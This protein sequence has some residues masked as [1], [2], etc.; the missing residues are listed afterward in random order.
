MFE[1]GTAT[2][3]TAYLWAANSPEDARIHT[4]TLAPDA[5]SSYSAASGDSRRAVR[6]ALDVS[7]LEGRRDLVFVDGSHAYSYVEG[8]T[9]KAHAAAI[10][11]LVPAAHMV[12]LSLR[13]RIDPRPPPEDPC[14]PLRSYAP[15][16]TPSSR[17][18][19][20]RLHP[21]HNRPPTSGPNSRAGSRR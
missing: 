5:H 8:D 17:S 3:R 18:S 13:P 12:I 9:E 6:R 19:S 10:P 20:C 14:H 11:A 4:I 2:G 15:R 1:F 16:H 21:S 7:E